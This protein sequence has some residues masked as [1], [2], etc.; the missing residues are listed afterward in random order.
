MLKIV[1]QQPNYLV[2]YG[3]GWTGF[4][5]RRDN[6]VSEGINWFSRWDELSHVPISHCFKIID[7]DLIVEALA[8]GVVRGSLSVYLNDPD[9]A[10]LVRRP[11]MLSD[12]LT[13]LLC[14]NA[15]EHLG[16]PYNKELIAALA[17][18]ETYLGRAANWFTRGW[19]Q[20]RLAITADER[21]TWTCSKLE[22]TTLHITPF[23]N[24]RGI[25]ELPP[26]LV[27]PIDL[28]E[29]IHVFDTELLAT[30]DAFELMPCGHD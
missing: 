16:E 11:I 29:D 27:K 6:F 4:V 26:C 5:S 17:I 21:N 28:F 3:P 1:Q 7:R 22:A 2:N 18:G 20:R 30:A 23:N 12:I 14:Q 8:S 24:L 9:I 15:L 19:L 10:L 25:M 13:K